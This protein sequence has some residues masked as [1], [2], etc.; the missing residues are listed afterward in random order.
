MISTVTGS[1]GAGADSG[2][3]DV[4]TRPAALGV[5]FP[6]AAHAPVLG[7]QPERMGATRIAVVPNPSPANAHATPADQTAWYDRL[8][9][10]VSETR[11]RA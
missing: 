5:V 7:L 3:A 11:P 6:D 8:A 4:T 2:F 1:G 9:T 10:L